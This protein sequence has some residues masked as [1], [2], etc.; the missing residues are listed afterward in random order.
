[1]GAKSLE[2]KKIFVFSGEITQQKLVKGKRGGGNKSQHVFSKKEINGCL[3][4]SCK[5]ENLLTSLI[6]FIVVAEC[7]LL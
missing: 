6:I 3:I 2:D 7:L 5:E 4:R 1:M